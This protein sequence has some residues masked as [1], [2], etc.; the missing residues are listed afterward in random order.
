VRSPQPCQ[1]PVEPASGVLGPTQGFAFWHLA[2]IATRPEFE[3][4]IR[5]TDC[6]RVDVRIMNN[7]ISVKSCSINHVMQ[8]SVGPT[9]S[10]SRKLERCRHTRLTRRAGPQALQRR[11]HPMVLRAWQRVGLWL[12]SWDEFP[13]LEATADQWRILLAMRRTSSGKYGKWC[14]TPR[15]HCST[16]VKQSHYGKIHVHAVLSRPPD[17]YPTSE[18]NC[19]IAAFPDFH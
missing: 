10:W 5:Q 16:L 19:G 14:E 9:R 1:R 7:S 6:V 3:T 12:T 8:E 18:L 15:I 17:Q 13:A 11:V 4:G 2:I